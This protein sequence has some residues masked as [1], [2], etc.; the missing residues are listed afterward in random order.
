MIHKKMANNDKDII[1]ITAFRDIGRSSWSHYQ[2]NTV[3]YIQRFFNLTLKLNNRIVAF[4]DPPVI[5]TIL[6]SFAN[7][8]VQTNGAIKFPVNLTLVSYGT[9]K[10]W[11]EFFE[12]DC[13]ILS[14]ESYKNLI[15]ERRKFNPEHC[16]PG[17]NLANHVKINFIKQVKDTY[18]DYRFYAWVDFGFLLD[19]PVSLS[20][21]NIDN[22]DA[23]KVTFGRQTLPRK[24]D[25]LEML[26]TD[27]IYIRGGT[28]FIPKDLVDRF[29]DLYYKKLQQWYNE[30][31]ITDDDQNLLLQLYNDEPSLF[32]LIAAD[33]FTLLY[34]VAQNQ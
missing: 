29:E 3:E 11:R 10:Y 7:A 25:A 13:T 30:L 5:Q 24:I 8:E 31:H 6:T 21:V 32:C 15:P 33:W 17:Y 34:T 28:F 2:R 9:P 23:S 4:V 1:F 12:L 19:R 22:L 26:T 20:K 27:E 16:R 14:S 18:P